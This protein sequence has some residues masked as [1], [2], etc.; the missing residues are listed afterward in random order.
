M[1]FLVLCLASALLMAGCGGKTISPPSVILTPRLANLLPGQTQDFIATVRDSSNTGVVWTATG[2][3]ISSNGMFTAGSN[4]GTYSVTAISAADNNAYAVAKINIKRHITISISPSSASLAPGGT[5]QFS[6]TATGGSSLTWSATGGTIS[7]SGLYTAGSS[8]GNFSVTATSTINSSQKSSVPVTILSA[9]SVGISPQSASLMAGQTQQFSATVSGSSNTGVTWTA[10]G[11]TISGSGLYTAGSSAGSFKVTATSAADPSQSASATIN[12][13]SATAVSVS[14]T[15]SS[16]SLNSG[17]TQQFTAAVSGSTNTG[18]TWTAT[19]GTITSS[20]LYSAGSATGNF[21]VT[22]TSAA[23]T[24][25]SASA[26]VTISTGNTTLLFPTNGQAAWWLYSAPTGTPI[27]ISNTT[28]GMTF[29]INAHDGGYD[30]PVQYADGSNGCT[31]F[32]DVGSYNFN[33]T[34]CVPIPTGGF[35]PSWGTDGHLIVLNKNT[36]TYYDFWKLTVNSSGQPLSTSVGAIFSGTLQGNG[37]PGTTAAF[38]TGLAG[39]ILPGELDCVT[40]LNHAVLVIVPGSMDAPGVGD[41]GPVYHYDG[42]VQGALFKEGEK[43]RFDPSI[44]VNTL[45]ASTATKALIRALQ[46][47][48]GLIIDQTGCNCFGI[49]SALATTPDKTGMSL[50]GQHLLLYP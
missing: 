6:A 29:N 4:S 45:T 50:I 34:Y 41:Q 42:S 13:Q 33:D 7:S 28:S 23:D 49:Y 32:T 14:V 19:G 20:G 48:G 27:N 2:G 38:V 11:G 44:D 46:L 26:A 43:I 16:V 31:T 8:P 12:I 15:P 35:Q 22:A 9:I 18:V 36:G 5:Q 21:A 47:Y 17:Q 30:Y 10:S 24:S 39:D 37:T 1:R 25:K 40:C 3:N